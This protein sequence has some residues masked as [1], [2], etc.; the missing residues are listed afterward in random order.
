MKFRKIENSSILRVFD[1]YLFAAE[2]GS[3]ETFSLETSD[4]KSTENVNRRMRERAP[5]IFYNTDKVP[6]RPISI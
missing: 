3:A 1:E 6:F 2:C 4:I 5:K